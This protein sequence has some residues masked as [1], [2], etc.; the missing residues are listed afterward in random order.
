MRLFTL[1]TC[2]CLSAPAWAQPCAPTVIVEATKKHIPVEEALTS[3]QRVRGLMHRKT[4]RRGSG[5][6]FVF[7]SS[8]PRS[9]WMRNTTISLDLIFVDDQGSVVRVIERAVPLSEQALRSV[10]PALYVLEVNAGEAAVLG[11]KVGGKLSVCGTKG[12]KQP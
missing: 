10:T 2:L 11:I 7:E 8:K 3:K 5:M 12:P 4:L 1:A 9:F 6:W